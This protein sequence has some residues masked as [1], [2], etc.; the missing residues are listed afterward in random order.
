MSVAAGLRPF[1]RLVAIKGTESSLRDGDK[2]CKSF[3]N[4]IIC[5][6]AVDVMKRIPDKM[7]NLIITSPPYNLKN[8]TG[9]GMKD[10]RGG[11][12]G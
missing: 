1:K 10:G 11:K 8:F 9:N 4:K 5:G 6:S 3:L 2:F 7:V 12:M